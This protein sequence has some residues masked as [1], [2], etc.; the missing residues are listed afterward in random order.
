MLGSL[1]FQPTP[2]FHWIGQYPFT[3]PTM[4][5]S[6]YLGSSAG[7]YALFRG[8]LGSMDLRYIGQT[9]AFNSRLSF[10]HEAV[11]KILQES[12]SSKTQ[13]YVAF[14]YQSNPYLRSQIEEELIRQFRPAYN[15]QYNL[16]MFAGLQALSRRQQF[17]GG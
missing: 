1:S 7:I 5:E 16:G 4:L 10:N 13:V 15:V 12:Y 6:A 3:I 17:L 14:H 2:Q 9:N 11:Q 8:T